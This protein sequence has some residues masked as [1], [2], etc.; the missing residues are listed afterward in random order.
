MCEILECLSGILYVG[1]T[2]VQLYRNVIHVRHPFHSVHHVFRNECKTYQN[3][4]RSLLCHV[5]VQNSTSI[6]TSTSSAPPAFSTALLKQGLAKE[7]HNYAYSTWK[8]L[9]R[10]SQGAHS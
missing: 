7:A 3:E 1:A 2:R 4:K 5:L 8:P 6:S 9:K 10:R